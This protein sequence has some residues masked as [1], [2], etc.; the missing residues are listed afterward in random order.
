[1]PLL[2]FHNR[3]GPATAQPTLLRQLQ[4]S[5]PSFSPIRPQ[6]IQLSFFDGTD[7]LDWLF[8]ADQFFQFYNIPW[9]VIAFYMRGDALSWFKWMYQNHQL[10][11]WISFSR[12]LELRFGPS[13][14]ENHQAKLFKLCQTSTAAEYKKLF[15]KIRNRVMG[16]HPEMILNYF[17]SG[18]L[19]EIQREIAVLQPISITQAMGLTKLLESKI[20]DSKRSFHFSHTLP[21]P[22]N[23]L[24]PSPRSSPSPTT[25][26]HATPSIPIKKVTS[27]QLQERKIAGL[28]YNRD[29]KKIP[30]HK[31]TTHRFLLLLSDD[32]PEENTMED[33]PT[34]FNDQPTDTPTHIHLSL[35]ALCGAPS[36][37]TFTFD[38][39][40]THLPIT[41]LIDTGS[42][43]NIIQPR[44][45]LHLQ[46]CIVPITPLLVMVQ[47]QQN[48]VFHFLP[49]CP[50]F[51][52]YLHFSHFLL[53]LTYRRG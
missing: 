53:P 12:A 51:Y 21:Q 40:I 49:R 36:T 17:I 13:T 50:L 9:N 44:F 22:S 24:L 32:F 31:C 48:S 46:L 30:G 18:L 19:P 39:Y 23:H 33:Y 47:W 41:I 52:T 26:T 5:P 4:P 10:T 38:G 1:M 15:E 7:P 25:T 28:C 43:H 35:Q 20:Q 2:L 29:E 27:T 16:L 34:T 45:A 3:L 42:S 8:Q 14:Y 37:H 6:K 11:D